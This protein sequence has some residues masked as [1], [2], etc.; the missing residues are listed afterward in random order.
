[1]ERNS[2]TKEAVLISINDAE[3][4]MIKNGIVAV[5]DICNT[6]DTLFQ[7]S[8]ANLQYYNFIETFEVH[9]DKIGQAIEASI[10]L[11]RQ[12]REAKLKAT[13]VPHAAYSVPPKMM[14]KIIDYTSTKNITILKSEVSIT[15]KSFFK[16]FGFKVIMKQESKANKLSLINYLMEKKLPNT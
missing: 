10:L 15:A 4:Q 14:Q 1:M 6:S 12:F 9:D 11:R 8:K 2:F 7:K 16:S 3:K 5:G 13:I